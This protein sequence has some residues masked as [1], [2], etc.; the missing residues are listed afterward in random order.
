MTFPVHISFRDL[1]PSSALEQHI[2]RKAEKLQ[3]WSRFV[4][5]CDVAIESPHKRHAHGNHF[6]VRIH[7]GVPGEDIVID[8]GHTAERATEDAHALIDVAFDDAGRVIS[9]RMRRRRERTKP[10]RARRA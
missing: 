3:R 4:D 2:R 1:G 10:R 7:V 5:Y 8:Q 9:E 6:R